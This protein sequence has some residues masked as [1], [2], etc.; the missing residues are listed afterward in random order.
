MKNLGKFLKKIAEILEVK[1]VSKNDNLSKFEDWASLSA[2]SVIALVNEMYKKSI[3]VE[4]LEKFSTLA[5]LCDFV[6]SK[7]K[8]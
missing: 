5:K 7:G 2:L 8:K 3:S 1:K 6:E 4:K